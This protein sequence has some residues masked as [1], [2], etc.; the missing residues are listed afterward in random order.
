MKYEF[1]K[2]IQVPRLVSE[3]MRLLGTIEVPGLGN[4]PLIIEW[5]KEVGL[6][7]VYKKDE[8]PWCGLFMA[9]IVQ[10]S[11]R[12]VITD[13]LWA[14]NWSRFGIPVQTPM[15]GDILT[16]KR[17]GGGHVGVYIAEDALCYHVLGGNQ[18]DKVS[19]ARIIKSRL[20]AARRP[21]YINTPASMKRYFVQG[22]GNISEN[23]S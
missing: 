23:E 11:K 14:L 9:V 12:Q 1:L 18:G 17:K 16:F 3:G 13:P 5:A 21:V 6:F 7:D 10:R 20:H 19:I 4:N 22:D 8:T 15:L 2:S